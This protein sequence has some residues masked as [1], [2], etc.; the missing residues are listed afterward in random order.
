[1]NMSRCNYC[2][3]TGFSARRVEY[4]YAHGGKYLLAPNTPAEV[5]DCCGMEFYDAVVVKEIERRF[6]AIRAKTEKPDEVLQ[7]PMKA[8]A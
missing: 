3:G 4:F 1:M 7:V 5:C 2:G 8:F 6:F